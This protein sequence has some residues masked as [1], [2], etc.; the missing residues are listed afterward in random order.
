M[1]DTAYG[2]YLLHL[3]VVIPLAG[4]LSCV[5]AYTSAPW[6][7]RFFVVVTIAAA[8]ADPVAWFLHRLVEQPGIRW[9]KI[10]VRRTEAPKSGAPAVAES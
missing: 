4:L 6:P 5:G 8:I 2:F 9:G 3:L 7:V 1:G 10:V